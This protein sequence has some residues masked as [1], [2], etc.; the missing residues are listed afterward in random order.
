MGEPLQGTRWNCSILPDHYDI[1]MII[2]EIKYLTRPMPD[3]MQLRQ[4]SCNIMKV[5]QDPCLIWYNWGKDHTTS[6]RSY[7]IHVWSGIIEAR[8]M[9]ILHDLVQLRQGWWRS[10]MIWH[11]NACYI[12]HSW[13]YAWSLPIHW[14]SYMTFPRSLPESTLFFFFKNRIKI[15]CIEYTTGYRLSQATNIF[16]G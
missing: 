16:M 14:H 5:L 12:T 15:Y 4:G 6:Q 9:K 7:K 8:V 1:I 13:L 3:L 11:H 10:C 2:Q